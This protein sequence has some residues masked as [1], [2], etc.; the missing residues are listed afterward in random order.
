MFGTDPSDRRLIAR[1]AAHTSW[2]NTA[3]RTARTA[4]ARAA[5]LAQ[6]EQQVDPHG[7]LEAHERARRAVHARKAHFGRL[8]RKSA[9]ARRDRA[10]VA[11]DLRLGDSQ[12]TSSPTTS[13]QQIADVQGQS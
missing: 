12:A 4:P 7:H 10:D 6:F 3:N 8:A 1:I 11:V 13:V 2:A 9:Q 5:L